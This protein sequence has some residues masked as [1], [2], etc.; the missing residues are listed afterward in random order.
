LNGFV[1]TAQHEDYNTFK[2]CCSS[3]SFS[4]YSGELDRELF[5]RVYCAAE[6]N[7]CSPIYQP[8][9]QPQASSSA[10]ATGASTSTP[11]ASTSTSTPRI[12]IKQS[13]GGSTAA[14]SVAA[15]TQDS[16]LS[17]SANASTAE[18]AGQ[19]K[20]EDGITTAANETNAASPPT[21]PPSKEVGSSAINTSLILPGKR[22]RTS[23]T[24]SGA[25]NTASSSS[26][27]ATADAK[28]HQVCDF[29]SFSFLKRSYDTNARAFFPH[30]S[31][32]YLSYFTF[33]RGCICSVYIRVN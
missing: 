7:L 1:S 4:I 18:T 6:L 20:G 16:S 3:R 11:A 17:L 9:T 14:T 27:A 21:P 30:L 33:H 28:L 2:G 5:I 19:I 22:K 8:A 26:A 23:L 32:D 24:P 31:L 25:N 12:R 29:V 15:P 10:T 13:G